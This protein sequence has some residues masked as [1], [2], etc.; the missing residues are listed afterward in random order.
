MVDAGEW[1]VVTANSRLVLGPCP[2]I[3]SGEGA[4]VLVHCGQTV[5]GQLCFFIVGLVPPLLSAGR[6]G[7][8]VAISSKGPWRGNSY[9]QTSLV[10]KIQV[11]QNCSEFRGT[12]L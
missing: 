5:C 1:L 9:K 8:R 6:G 11:E 2:Y 7:H 10:V 12:G 4:L 3:L